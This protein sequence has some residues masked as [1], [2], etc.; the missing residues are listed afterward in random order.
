M[1]D[2]KTPAELSADDLD[3]AVGGAAAPELDV[4]KGEQQ[5]KFQDGEQRRKRD[6]SGREDKAK[7]L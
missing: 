1:T 3:M 5:I 2:K 4:S 7:Q 6:V